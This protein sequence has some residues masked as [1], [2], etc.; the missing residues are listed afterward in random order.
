M[1]YVYVLVESQSGFDELG[2]YFLGIFGWVKFVLEQFFVSQCV[3]YC[4]E[5]DCYFQ[6]EVYWCFFVQVFN[7]CFYLLGVDGQGVEYF[8]VQDEVICM[9]FLFNYVV[10]D[11][12]GW[13][14]VVLLENV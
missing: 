10:V 3:F 11:C 9:V 2:G 13:V 1:Q 4:F 14:L 12:Y 6:F 8:N 5:E 7:W